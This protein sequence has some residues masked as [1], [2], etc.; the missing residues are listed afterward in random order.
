[1]K[2]WLLCRFSTEIGAILIG[3]MR[4]DTMEIRQLIY[5]VE[6]AKAGSFTG[7]AKIM[8]ITQPALSKIIKALE[9]ELGILLF[10][11]SEKVLQLTDTG[12]EFYEK[13]EK[14]ILDFNALTDS[15]KDIESLKKGHIRIGIPPVI[16]TCYFPSLIAGFREKHPGVT[17]TILEEGARTVH[18][19]VEE[20]SIDMGIVILPIDQDKF[21]IIP[22]ISD[23]NVL[24]VNIEHPL[25]N[26][27]IVRYEELK[28]ENFVLLNETSMLHDQIIA[29]C[30]ESGFEPIVTVK[31]SQW[32]FLAELVSLNQGISILPKPIIKRFNTNLIKVIPIDHSFVRWR[33]AIILKKERYVSF[34]M[35][36]FIV[37]IQQ[38]IS[39]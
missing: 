14:L 28:D 25:A 11:R 20:G 24:I 29:A 35:K 38:N 5:F 15:V 37:Y 2:G 33:V 39:S 18:D 32:D 12:K 16:G 1:M 13:A 6:I 26:K 7:A 19:K 22:I 17:I 21:D 31:S 27:K 9:Y 4:C 23:D 3:M 30:K 10:D 8:H 34:A 36:E